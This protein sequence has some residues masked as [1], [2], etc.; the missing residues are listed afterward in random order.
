MNHFKEFIA[1]ILKPFDIVK[2]RSL[3]TFPF[4]FE[5]ISNTFKGTCIQANLPSP[6]RPTSRSYASEHTVKKAE[7][8]SLLTPTII[9]KKS[10]KLTNHPLSELR[11]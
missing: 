5:L 1:K 7:T 3:F 8:H 11:G 2:L 6:F 9:T 10:K 4:T